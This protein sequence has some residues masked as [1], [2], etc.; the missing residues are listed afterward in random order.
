[1]ETTIINAGNIQTRSAFFF[2]CRQFHRKKN[3][4]KLAPVKKTPYLCHV[5]NS[6]A[7][8]MPPTHVGSFCIHT[9]Q[10]LYTAPCRVSGNAPGSSASETLTTRSAV[11]FMSK[12]ISNGDNNHQRRE[13]L[14]PRRILFPL[15]PISSQ[16]K[17]AKNLHRSKKHSIFAS[18]IKR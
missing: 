11:F 13:R 15:P 2:P 10:Q 7:V 16:K 6:I 17:I 14:D 4:E 3:S 1:M 12:I 5:K 18:A 9:Y 8:Q